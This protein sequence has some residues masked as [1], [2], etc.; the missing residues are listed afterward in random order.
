VEKQLQ[1]MG[2]ED[3]AQKATPAEKCCQIFGWLLM[4][5]GIGT[6]TIVQILTNSTLVSVIGVVML[7][8]GFLLNRTGVKKQIKRRES[9]SSQPQP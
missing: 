4:L 8:A 7:V 9:L 5:F 6:V 3:F 1:L 2:K